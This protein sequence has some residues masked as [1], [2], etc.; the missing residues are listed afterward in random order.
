MIPTPPAHRS[1]AQSDLKFSAVRGTISLRSSKV[2]LAAE[3]PTETSRNTD[4]VHIATRKKK[5]KVIERG[6]EDCRAAWGGRGKR[7]VFGESVRAKSRAGVKDGSVVVVYLGGGVANIFYNSCYT[8]CRKSTT[9]MITAS[10]G[11]WGS[12]LVV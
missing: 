3:P 6:G 10:I 2:S 4:G 7:S 11:L 8:G 9:T 12:L 1:P 5:E